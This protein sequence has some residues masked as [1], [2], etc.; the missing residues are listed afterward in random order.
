MLEDV[1]GCVKVRVITYHKSRALSLFKSYSCIS[2]RNFVAI[3]TNTLE[4]NALEINE[5]AKE[6]DRERS[7]TYGEK[8]NPTNKLQGT[9]MGK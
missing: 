5:G 4:T 9:V 6:V 8:S 2:R 3:K 7:I 1:E